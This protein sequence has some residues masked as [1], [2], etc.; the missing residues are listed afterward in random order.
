[1]NEWSDFERDLAVALSVL[2][3]EILVVSS[4]SCKRPSAPR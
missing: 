3:D 2:K 1:M 4:I